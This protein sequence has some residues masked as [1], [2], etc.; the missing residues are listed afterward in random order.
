MFIHIFELSLG[1][2]MKQIVPNQKDRTTH[3][4]M[5]STVFAN[6]HF[7]RIPPVDYM[8][9]LWVKDP[10]FRIEGTWGTLFSLKTL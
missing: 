3:F 2:L 5:M 6:I 8:R 1:N 7:Q 4:Q 10:R 9:E